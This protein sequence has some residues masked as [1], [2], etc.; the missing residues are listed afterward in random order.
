[1]YIHK[2]IFLYDIASVSFDIGIY[3]YSQMGNF[4]FS[5]NIERMKEKLFDA[6]KF[7]K[8]LP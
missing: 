6:W 1:M 3:Q 4:F 8:T 7:G 2:V 5:S